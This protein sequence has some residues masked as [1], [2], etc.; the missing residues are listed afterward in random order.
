MA[1]GALVS[2]DTVRCRPFNAHRQYGSRHSA[3]SYMGLLRRQVV[4]R[5]GRGPRRYT[6]DEDED[7]LFSFKFNNREVSVRQQDVWKYAV[8]SAGLF[9][10]SFVIGPVVAGLAFSVFALGAAFSMGALALTTLFFPLLLLGGFGAVIFGSMIFGAA[11]IGVGLILPQ[12]IALGGIALAWAFVSTLT[13]TRRNIMKS[14]DRA[15]TRGAQNERNVFE[16]ES[17]VIQA[18]FKEFDQKLEDRLKR[19][20]RRSKSRVNQDLY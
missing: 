4:A 15:N 2:P 18:E 7:E 19:G 6:H 5:S 14:S 16:E 8:P 13:G 9:L 20:A 1:L 11:S 3:R 10:A 12:V 17:D